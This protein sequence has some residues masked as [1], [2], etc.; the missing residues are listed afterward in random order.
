[1]SVVPAWGMLREVGKEAVGS[2]FKM[3]MREQIQKGHWVM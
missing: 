1:M 3:E 2:H